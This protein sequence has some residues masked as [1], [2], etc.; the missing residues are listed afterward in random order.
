MIGVYDY[1]VLATYLSLAFGV[2][3][4]FSAQDGAALSALLCL[5]LSGLLDAFDG[6]QAEIV[7]LCKSLSASAFCRR[8]SAARSAADG[9][10]ARR[11]CSISSPR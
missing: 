5:M 6:R 8:S 7:R 11:R 4:I 2:L 10:C 9:R 3:G 1:T